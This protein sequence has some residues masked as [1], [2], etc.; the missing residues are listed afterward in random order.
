MKVDPVELGPRGFTY[1]NAGY[2]VAGAM[3]EKASGRSWEDLMRDE[4]F[5][6]FGIDGRVGWPA[7]EEEN[8]PWGH[9][10]RMGKLIPHDP[11]DEYQIPEIIY[12]GGNINMSIR[13][14]GKWLQALLR[15]LKDGD[16]NLK[17]S[18]YKFL[19]SANREF[20]S[21]A[22]GWGIHEEDGLSIN[23]HDGSAGTFYCHAVVIR[24]LDL[25]LAVM[26]NSAAPKVI[27]GVHTL[28][29]RIIQSRKK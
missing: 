26:T 22:M 27:E 28:G 15:G 21:Y 6:P 23:A 19:L 4:I 17:A 13:D 14:Y 10:M 5:I 20:S 24:E 1:S 2:A 9:W 25:G 7:A 12:P 18:I 3:L 11:H 8:Q 29:R 16:E